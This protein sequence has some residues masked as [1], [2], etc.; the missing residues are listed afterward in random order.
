ML[1][2]LTGFMC[3]GKTTDGKAAADILK[4]PFLDLD[5]EL[6]KQS[7]TTI[8]SFI[9]HKGITDFRKLESEILL[10]SLQIL[11]NQFPGFS[12]SSGKPSTV[13]ATGGGCVLLPENREFLQ[14]TGNAVIWLNLPF[15][16]LL[17]RIHNIQRPLLKDLSDEEIQQLYLERLQFYQ[18][19]ATHQIT[20]QP[21]VEQII[22]SFT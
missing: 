3:S 14:K 18:L 8:S 20:S 19:T 2:Y 6:E 4:V 1:I 17:E 12:I 15:S 22:T 5:A 9:E 21:V 13:I 10:N 7:G 11:Q 16:L